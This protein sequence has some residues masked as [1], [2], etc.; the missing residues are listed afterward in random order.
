MSVRGLIGVLAMMGVVLAV[1]VAAP[2]SAN[3]AADSVMALGLLLVAAYLLGLAAGRF[4]V[5]AIT[6]YIVAGLAFGPDVL[7]KIAPAFA[8]IGHE[9]LATLQLFDG[10][11]LGLIALTAGGELE[12]AIVKKRLTSMVAIIAAQVVLV[13]LGVGGLLFAFASWIPGLSGLGT[14]AT[15]AACLLLGVT[16]VAKSPATTIAVLQQYRPKGPMSDVVLAVTVAKDVVVVMMFTV[17]LAAAVL[18]VDTTATL[19]RHVFGQLAWEIFGS[20]GLGLLV[21]WLLAWFAERLPEEL[22]VAVVGVAFLSGPL[23]REYHLSGLLV[24][25]VAGFCVENFSP[26]G[27]RLIDAVERHSLVLYVVF[28]A[29]AGAAL[30]LDALSEMWLLAL[31]LVGLRMLFTFA[32]TWL[33]ARA[34]GDPPGVRRYAWTGFIGQAG[35]TLGFAGLI[36]ERLPGL[37]AS[38]QTAIIAAVAVNQLIGPPIF[39]AGLRKSGELRAGI[40][41]FRL[42]TG[43]FKAAQIETRRRPGAPKG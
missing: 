12:M 40:A 4:N 42:R 15:L 19:D 9:G 20:I 33:G 37:G 27:R 24:C 28:F 29:A 5:P 43:T 13:I 10:A 8:V 22:A 3:N 36:G 21:G 7:G 30:D 2:Q 34:V 14:E 1:R 41:P 35:V 31:S 32:A 23:N 38:L 26:H 25:M 16:A 18:L 11:A 17:A 6:G 39:L